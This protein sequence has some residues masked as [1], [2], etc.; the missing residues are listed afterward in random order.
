MW[1]RMGL[2]MASCLSCNREYIGDLSAGPKILVDGGGFNTVDIAF[3]LV[4][5]IVASH[6]V[7]SPVYVDEAIGALGQLDVGA[8]AR[9]TVVESV[10]L[11]FGCLFQTVLTL[12]SSPTAS[13]LQLV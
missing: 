3:V 13:A 5:A 7:S 9:D 1:W 2:K 11:I 12:L 6:C 10:R 4:I 8:K